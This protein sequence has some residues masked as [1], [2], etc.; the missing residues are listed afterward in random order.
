MASF[1]QR[2]SD[3]LK[4]HPRTVALAR[5]ISV[6]AHRDWV[7][8]FFFVL[9]FCDGV[10]VFLP[11]D[12]LLAVTLLLAPDRHRP[13]I[14]AAVAGTLSSLAVFY[15][16]SL[17]PLKPAIIEFIR[18]S[19]FS[20]AFDKLTAAAAETGYLKLAIA[21][22]TV[23]PSLVCLVGG[24]FVGLNPILVLFISLGGRILRLFAMIMVMRTLKVSVVGIKN[25]IVHHR[26]E[27]GEREGTAGRGNG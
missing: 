10:L 15:F 26:H 2:I 16:A 9:F 20:H 17:S 22:L 19:D 3:W 25:Y 5:K 27:R 1:R 8:I 18:Q 13:W 12:S 23:V 21:V 4:P 6:Q 7:V 24:I 11:S 14:L